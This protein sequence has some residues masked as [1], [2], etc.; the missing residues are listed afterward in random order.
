MGLQYRRRKTR[1]PRRRGTRKQRGGAMQ[2]FIKTLSGK[3]LT[4]DVDPSDTIRV[5]KDKIRQKEEYPESVTVNSPS[6]PNLTLGGRVLTN[7]KTLSELGIEKE[8]T[9]VLNY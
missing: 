4:I 8:T 5:V 3:R 6:F 2:I 7:E 9:L 1:K